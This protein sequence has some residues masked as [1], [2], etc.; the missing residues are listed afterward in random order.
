MWIFQKACLKWV[1]EDENKVGLIIE[2]QLGDS[3]NLPF[4]DNSFDA[5]TADLGSNFENLQKG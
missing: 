2:L 3:E 5:V 4:D 1:E